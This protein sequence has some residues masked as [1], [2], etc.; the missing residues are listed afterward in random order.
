MTQGLSANSGLPL[1]PVSPCSQRTALRFDSRPVIAEFD[2][3]NKRFHPADTQESNCCC[4]FTYFGTLL[5]NSPI[6]ATSHDLPVTLPV[7]PP[8]AFPLG[9]T[10]ISTLLSP[11]RSGAPAPYS[12]RGDTRGGPGWMEGK[13]GY[14]SPNFTA[15]WRFPS[16]GRCPTPCAPPAPARHGGR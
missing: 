12:R 8:M 5:F 10:M 13:V 11:T 16:A 15:T 2:Q 4:D 14:N 1:S 7:R 6:N 9:L 3:L